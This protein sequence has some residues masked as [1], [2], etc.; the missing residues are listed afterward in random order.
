MGLQFK[1]SLLKAN[2]MISLN[3]KLTNGK[4]ENLLFNFSFLVTFKK[5]RLQ[6]Q[7]Y[8]TSEIHIAFNIQLR[9]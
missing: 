6:I 1:I 3:P 5:N 7:I 8:R 4:A 2:A 9:G